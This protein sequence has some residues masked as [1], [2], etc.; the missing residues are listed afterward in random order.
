MLEHFQFAIREFIDWRTEVALTAVDRL[1]E[2]LG[3]ADIVVH[4]ASAPLES[5]PL[6]DLSPQQL[7]RHVEVQA[8]GLQRL[9]QRCSGNMLRNGTGHFIYVGSTVVRGAPAKGLAAYS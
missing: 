5:M 3:A 4:A 2:K 6:K 9:F 1:E 8:G 7:A